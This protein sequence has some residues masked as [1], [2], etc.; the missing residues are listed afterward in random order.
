MIQAIVCSSVPRSGAITSMRG[1]MMVSTSSVKRRVSRSSSPRRQRGRV[2]GD[3]AL[4]AA[5]RQVHDAALPRH[6]HGQGR[7]LAEVDAGVVAQAALGRAAGQ[8]VL[9]AVADED[10]GAAVVHAD[11]DADDHGPLGQAQAFEDA[12]VD[13]DDL[14]HGRRAG[15][16][17]SGRS[18][19]CRRAGRAD[20]VLPLADMAAPGA[21]GRGR[22]QRTAGAS[23]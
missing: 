8:A 15:G 14:G 3:A 16:R 10:L 22:T 11:R 13:V 7:H 5:E 18:A 6:P 12:V 23:P 17:P 9:H 21:G 1:P 19:S 2:A 4:G 20:P